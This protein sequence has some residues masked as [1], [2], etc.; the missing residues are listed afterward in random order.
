MDVDQAV[1]AGDFHIRKETTTNE[2][3]HTPRTDQ[4]ESNQNAILEFEINALHEDG[5]STPETL[6]STPAK[7]GKCTLSLPVPIQNQSSTQ[8]DLN[9][10]W[11]VIEENHLGRRLKKKARLKFSI[12]APITDKIV[13][14]SE[15]AEVE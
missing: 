8:T 13:N 7:S 11:H 2:G 9:S 5:G 4:E 6:E 10:Q 1:T 15:K 14:L 3:P 12:D